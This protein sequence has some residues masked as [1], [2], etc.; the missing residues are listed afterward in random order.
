MS[1]K[2]TTLPSL[3]NKDCK[4]V[5]AETKRINELLIHPDEKYDRRKRTNLCRSEISL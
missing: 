5:K 4:T 1:E 2:K 3:R